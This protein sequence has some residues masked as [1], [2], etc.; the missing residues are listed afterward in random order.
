M[1]FYK[2]K[3]AALAIALSAIMTASAAMAATSIEDLNGLQTALST[4]GEYQLS[5]NITAS[6][7]LNVTANVVLDLNGNT[8][9]GPTNVYVF[10]IKDGGALTVDDTNTTETSGR[11]TGGGHK[12]VNGRT[13][14]FAA[15]NISDG[16]ALTL[17]NGTI[18]GNEYYA[19]GTSGGTFTMNG[20]VLDVE[21]ADGA[22]VAGNGSTSSYTTININ[23]GEIKGGTGANGCAIYHPQDGTLTIS[24]GTITGYDGVQMKGGTFVMTGGSITATG[25]DKIDSANYSKASDG[26]TTTG[27]ALSLLSQKGYKGNISATISDDAVLTSASNYAVVEAFANESTD[28]KTVSVNIEGGTF[29]GGEEAAVKFTNHNE[30]GDFSVSGGTYNSDPSEYLDEGIELIQEGDNWVA[31]TP[32]ATPAAPAHSGGG[33]GGCSA[34][35]G[36]LALLAAVPLLFRRKK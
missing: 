1:K 17:Q 31:K 32:A 4:D 21:N 26:N 5:K 9:T 6:T 19:V 16:G 36:A 35:F 12:L 28:L 3:I 23:G 24:G 15:I 10:D 8:I 27:C 2:S 30:I 22:T 7:T 18:H 29:K 20:G 33:S 14:Y 11:I 13:G 25:A 34:G